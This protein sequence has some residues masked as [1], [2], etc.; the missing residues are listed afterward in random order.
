[1]TDQEIRLRC[2]ELAAPTCGFAPE[3]TVEAARVLSDFVLG[4]NDA[5]VIRAARDLAQKVSDDR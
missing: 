1:M 2:I 4:R 5:E 3:A